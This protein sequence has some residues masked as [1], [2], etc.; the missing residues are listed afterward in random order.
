M[1]KTLLG[2]LLDRR[3]EKTTAAGMMISVL[4]LALLLLLPSVFA[5]S[6]DLADLHRDGVKLGFLIIG[7][8]VLLMLYPERGGRR[9][10]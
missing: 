6:P 5:G 2:F 10:G 4:G 1:I 8:G 3:G 7:A 9:G